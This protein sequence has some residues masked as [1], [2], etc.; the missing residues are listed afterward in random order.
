MKIVVVG[1]TGLIGKKLV[2]LLG[3]KGH[4]VVAASKSSGL[5]V[6]TG[7]GVHAAVAGAEVVVDVTNSPSF[8][9]EAVMSFFRSSAQALLPAEVAAGVRH[10][11]AL[12]VV[13]AERLPSSG[14]LRAKVAQEEA[15]V[16]SG[17]PYTVVRATQFHEF[18]GT[19]VDASTRDGVARLPTATLQTIA[20]DDVA[21]LLAETVVAAPARAT[22]EIGGPERV[23]LDEL[24]R[25]WLRSR[26]DTRSVVGDPGEGYFGARIEDRSLTTSAGARLGAVRFDEWLAR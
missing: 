16:A 18:V 17:L 19:I 4:A 8:E 22:V 7:E 6:L 20:A 14:Y 24:A 5:D 9:D 23:A 1:A 13:G 10:H 15:I 3:A 2:E 12:S 11:V 26:G 25:R 21:R